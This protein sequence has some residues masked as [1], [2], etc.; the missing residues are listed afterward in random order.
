MTL[1]ASGLVFLL[2]WN[3]LGELFLGAPKAVQCL[4]FLLALAIGG[5]AY[6]ALGLHVVLK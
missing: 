6:W 4:G 2:A 5:A 1:F 3:A